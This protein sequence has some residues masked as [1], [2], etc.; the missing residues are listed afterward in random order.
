M[1]LTKP[2]KNIIARWC[3]KGY[4]TSS[5]K[6]GYESHI[7]TTMEKRRYYEYPESCPYANWWLE[8]HEIKLDINKVGKEKIVEEFRYVEYWHCN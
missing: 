8:T 1:R 5:I 2:Q 6:S 3:Q 7:L 4:K